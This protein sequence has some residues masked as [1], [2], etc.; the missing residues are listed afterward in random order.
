MNSAGHSHSNVCPP[1]SPRNRSTNPSTDG[2]SV[3]NWYLT[4]STA[5]LSRTDCVQ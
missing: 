2:E 3:R 5:P 4:P 1:H